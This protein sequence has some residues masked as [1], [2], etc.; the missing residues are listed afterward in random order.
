VYRLP[1]KR[2]ELIFMEFTGIKSC[3]KNKKKKKKNFLLI[4]FLI[5]KDI[6]ISNE[7]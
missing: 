6:I 4:L 1:V 2:L 5:G 3:K 7:C